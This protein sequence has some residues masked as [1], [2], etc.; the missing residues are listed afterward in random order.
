M[1]NFSSRYFFAHT[2]LLEPALQP[3]P[4]PTGSATAAY[5]RQCQRGTTF[6]A[7]W[8]AELTFFYCRI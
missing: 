3:Q 8:H 2:W 6:A 7:W 1:I 4:Q 5:S